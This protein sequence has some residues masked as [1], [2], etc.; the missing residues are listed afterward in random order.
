MVSCPGID[1]G[2][3][4]KVNEAESSEKIRKDELVDIVGEELAKRW[5][6]L[7]EKNRVESGESFTRLLP[8]NVHSLVH[9]TLLRR[10][11]LTIPS[12]SDPSIA[13]CPR[14]ACQA[15]VAPL[16]DED[17][18]RVCPKCSYAFCIFC[19]KTW[20]GVR[21]PCALPQSSSIVSS[22][23]AGTPEE[24]ALLELKFGKANIRRLVSAFEEDRQ[25]SEWLNANSMG[26]PGCAVRVEKS[27][28]CSHMCCTS[29]SRRIADFG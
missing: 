22:Y 27:A 1:C 23:L 20:H 4:R 2:K 26:C 12:S 9:S 15:P 21:N 17:K 5:E 19:R 25:N 28:G 18:L 16:D 11:L 13:F 14:S 8:R 29:F 24:Q 10:L 3:R 7:V 6:L